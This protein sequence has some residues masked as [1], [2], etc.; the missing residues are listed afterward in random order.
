MNP[1]VAT[2]LVIGNLILGE[3]I[4]FS[5]LTFMTSYFVATGLGAVVAVAT[6]FGLETD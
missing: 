6:H 3:E 2:G 1:A 5:T 4:G